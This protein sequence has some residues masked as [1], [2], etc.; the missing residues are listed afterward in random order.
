VQTKRSGHLPIGKAVLSLKKLL[1]ARGR[2]VYDAAP[3]HAKHVVVRC[4]VTIAALMRCV[5]LW[6]DDRD[7]RVVG[8]LRVELRLAL[9]VSEMWETYV[10]D[11]PEARVRGLCLLRPVILPC[12][13]PNLPRFDSRSR[14]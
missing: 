12:A 6:S 9:P 4:H 10:L 13:S 14:C 8:S 3:I 11:H 2:V 5:L 1:G 7:G